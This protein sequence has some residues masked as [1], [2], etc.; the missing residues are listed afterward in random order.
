MDQSPRVYQVFILRISQRLVSINFCMYNP[1]TGNAI[2]A[3]CPS[4]IVSRSEYRSSPP[5]QQPD[6]S[7]GDP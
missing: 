5:T 2:E 3:P 1:H 6:T 7:E 4:R